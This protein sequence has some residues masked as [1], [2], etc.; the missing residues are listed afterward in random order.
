MKEEYI[1]DFFIFIASILL[2]PFVSKL[3]TW[4]RHEEVPKDW[5]YDDCTKE[6]EQFRRSEERREKLQKIFQKA[7]DAFMRT[8]PNIPAY[9][10]DTKGMTWYKIMPVYLLISSLLGAGSTFQSLSDTAE[11]N[12][13]TTAEILAIDPF[14]SLLT[15]SYP[16][17]Y[18]ILVCFLFVY[19]RNY[20]AKC[21]K[22][23]LLIPLISF[24]YSLI[25]FIYTYAEY[26]LT[27]GTAFGSAVSSCIIFIPSYFY[28][29]KR[30]IPSPCR[31]SSFSHPAKQQKRYFEYNITT[32]TI[33]DVYAKFMSES[34]Y[35]FLKTA[36]LDQND[37]VNQQKAFGLML[38]FLF[39]QYRL[40]SK[41]MMPIIA[42]MQKNM[43][44]NGASVNEIDSFFDMADKQYRNI[45]T[46]FNQSN[47]KDDP[48]SFFGVAV[49]HIFYPKKYDSEYEINCA[50]KIASAIDLF[51]F[52]FEEFEKQMAEKIT[53]KYT[54]Q[55]D[56]EEKESKQPKQPKY[57]RK[58]GSPLR[59]D[60]LFCEN[61]G[62]SINE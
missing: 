29:K 58:C 34:I 54:N 32:R 35:V 15:V 62:Q 59:T 55:A 40:E 53:E 42:S 19:M 12:N 20:N 49:Q 14:A 22:L 52:S 60:S 2:L 43:S 45:V 44:Y 25:V 1:L 17:V 50:A 23:T 5:P 24:A 26:G 11:A 31:P 48:N 27:D 51:T 4:Y 30:F 41:D 46:L 10:D 3:L 57:C 37:L 13:L 47:S 56:E 36:E 7:R 9:V 16:I 18:F 61:C 39:H 38:F 6:T 33:I 8:K 28:L 21:I